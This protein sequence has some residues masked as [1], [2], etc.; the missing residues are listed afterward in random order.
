MHLIEG[1]FYHIYNRGNNK[2]PIFFSHGN[3]LYFIK[4]IREQ[5][6]PVCDILAYCLMPNHF[7]LLIR[8]NENSV[9]ERSSFG[10]KPM[11]EFAYRTGV[12]LSS[13]SQAINKQQRTSGSLF[14]QKTKAKLLSEDNNGIIISYL[15]QC[16]YYI[17]QNPLAANL[18]NDLNGWPYS[19]YLDYAGLRNGTL[20]NKEILFKQTGIQPGDVVLKSKKVIDEVISGKIF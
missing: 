13:Y 18:V 7:H 5:L 1:E 8:A 20:C 19:S 4:K 11:Q 14:Q 16:F 17:H 2:Q 6:F 12:L 10:G 9:K 3:Y 15:E